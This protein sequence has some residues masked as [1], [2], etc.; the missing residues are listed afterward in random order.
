MGTCTLTKYIFCVPCIHTILICGPTGS[1]LHYMLQT[2][3]SHRRAGPI[4]ANETAYCFH[5]MLVSGKLKS[6]V[7]FSVELQAPPPEVIQERMLLDPKYFQAQE[8]IVKGRLVP[9]IV[10]YC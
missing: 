3:I 9:A 6:E 8:N 2:S 5:R 4:A 10:N 1:A 7:K